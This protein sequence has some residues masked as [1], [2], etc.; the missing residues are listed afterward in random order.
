MARWLIVPL[1][2]KAIP[3]KLGLTLTAA[4]EMGPP[5]AGRMLYGKRC[6]GMSDR[7]PRDECVGE[8]DIG[9]GGARTVCRRWPV[10]SEGGQGSTRWQFGKCLISPCALRLGDFERKT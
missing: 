3:E 5:L 9:P 6:V 4:L 10:R 1:R 8:A 2:N 7:A